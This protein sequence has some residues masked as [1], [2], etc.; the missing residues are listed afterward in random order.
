MYSLDLIS[1]DRSY[2]VKSH[3]NFKT[4]IGAFLSLSLIIFSILMFVYLGGFETPDIKASMEFNL[5]EEEIALVELPAMKI[6]YG[7]P[8]NLYDNLE[9]VQQ[10]G[11]KMTTLLLQDY[12]SEMWSE[13][14]NITM[15][16]NYVYKYHLWLNSSIIRVQEKVPTKE[17]IATPTRFYFYDETNSSCL[18]RLNEFADVECFSLNAISCYCELLDRKKIDNFLE[19]NLDYLDPLSCGAQHAALWAMDGYSSPSHW[20][21]IQRKTLLEY[22]PGKVFDTFDDNLAGREIFFATEQVKYDYETNQMKKSCNILSDI[23]NPVNFV[24]ALKRFTSRVKTNSGFLQMESHF[25]TSNFSTIQAKLIRK[26]THNLLFRYDI[27][28]VE[29]EIKVKRSKEISYELK[30]DQIAKIFSILINFWFFTYF[31]NNFLTEYLFTRY[32]LQR[33]KYK[34]CKINNADVE[35]NEI[36]N[37]SLKDYTFSNFLKYKLLFFLKN[38]ESYIKFEKQ[39]LSVKRLLSIEHQLLVNFEAEH[40]ENFLY[41]FFYKIDFLSPR[42]SFF[43]DKKIKFQSKF[44]SILTWI[45]LISILVLFYFVGKDFFEGTQHLKVIFTQNSIYNS[46]TKDIYPSIPILISYPSW[47]DPLREIFF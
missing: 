40:P 36:G 3:R 34:I 26:M 24:I 38:S 23:D 39:Y 32:V 35:F 8:K 31:F 20:C 9:V 29:A 43:I 6:I 18:L 2:Y 45:Y 12:T 17:N 47:V 7:F 25:L 44:G 37:H 46:K 15:N 42:R 21:N 4:K 28:D 41:R 1:S 14:F 27:K 22:N 10:D 13:Y 5:S 33:Y 30:S 16:P 19:I 11:E